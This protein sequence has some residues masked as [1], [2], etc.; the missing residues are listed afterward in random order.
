M[1]R[2]KPFLIIIISLTLIIFPNCIKKPQVLQY[3]LPH[4]P[5]PIAKERVLITVAGQGPEGLVV[6]K[7]CDD[8]KISNTFSYKATI[9]DLK[10][11]NSLLVAV[12]VSKVGMESIYTDFEQEK[13]RIIRLVAKANEQRIPIIMVYLGGSNRWDILNQEM[14]SAVGNYAN[15]IIAI[16]SHK[17]EDF[18]HG[19]AMENTIPFTLVKDM[20]RFHVP[21]N[22]AFR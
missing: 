9:E 1:A 3:T 13:Q 5:Y 16:S 22:S 19:I 8:L 4:L 20:E 18:F 2:S 6:A 11:I 12:G 7:I 15:Y 21:L 10:D 14:L 17:S